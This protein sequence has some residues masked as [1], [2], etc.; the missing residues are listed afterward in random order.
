M[1]SGAAGTATRQ[2]E[3]TTLSQLSPMNAHLLETIEGAPISEKVTPRELLDLKRGFGNEFIHR[4]NPET[5]Q[6]VKGTAAK[7]YHALGE[8]FNNAVPEAR[9]LNGRISRLIPIAKRGESAELNAPTTQRLFQRIA[10]PTGALTGALGGGVAGYERG[11]K[12]GAL[13]GASTGL[14]G[15]LLLTTPTGEMIMA[16]TVNGLSR[17]FTKLLAGGALQASDRNKTATTK[18]PK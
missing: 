2:G 7:T 1:L 10:A 8:E 12:K 16:R 17:P 6:G 15:P 9:E 18:V 14:L 4:W 5:M 3:R 11:G 13:E